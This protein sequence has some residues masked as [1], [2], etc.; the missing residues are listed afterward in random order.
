MKTCT[1][2]LYEV[3]QPLRIEDVEVPD[4][5]PGQVLV[6][7]AYSGVCHSQLME[8]RGKPGH[9]RY[10]PHLLGHEGSGVVVDVGEQVSKVQTGDR[11]VLTWIKGEKA[12]CGEAGSARVIRSSTP[13]RHTQRCL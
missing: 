2:V 4:L 11:V 13:A 10:L 6:K 7:V 8:A 9:D 1:A 3:D 12:E 5:R